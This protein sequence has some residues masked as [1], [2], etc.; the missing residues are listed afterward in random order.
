MKTYV[1]VVAFA[2]MVVMASCKKDHWPVYG[3]DKGN[4]P[5]RKVRFELYT[6]EN[7]ASDQK[8]IQFSLFMRTSGRTIFDSALATMK[9]ANIPD[10]LHRIIIEKYV[11]GNDT[12]TLAVGFEY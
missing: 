4:S 7:F 2:V 5:A 11:P 9:I 6:N 1:S 10:S 3:K 12:A 8:N